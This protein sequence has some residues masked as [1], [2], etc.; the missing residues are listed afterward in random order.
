M[1]PLFLGAL[2]GMAFGAVLMA[3]GLSNPRLI[4]G[5]LRLR[6]MRLLRLLV[7]A[8]ATGIVGI[9]FLVTFDAAHL[10]VKALHVIAVALGGVIFGIG[11]ALSGYCPG[12][13]L[14]ALAEGR[15]DALFAVAGGLLGTAAFAFSYASLRSVLIEP[16][17]FAAP[18]LHSWLG[19]PALVVALPIG[20]AAAWV[21]WGWRRAARRGTCSCKCKT[22]SAPLPRQEASE[23]TGAAA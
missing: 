19:V 2:T 18:T 17:S 1:N 11:F 23:K 21:V 8:I 15:R 13:S 12:T 4:I 22:P 9:A 7:T 3:S 6:D 10:A 20:A 14:A 16:L 5:M